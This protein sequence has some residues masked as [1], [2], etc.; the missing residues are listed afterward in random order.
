[1]QIDFKDLIPGTLCLF[2]PDYSHDDRRGLVEI[3]SVFKSGAIQFQCLNTASRDYY[4]QVCCTY[5]KHAF[6]HINQ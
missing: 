1:M 4:Q 6:K 2:E 3:I 5:Y